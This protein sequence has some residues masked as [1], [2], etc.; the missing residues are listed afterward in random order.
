MAKAT[1]ITIR[2]VDA[3]PDPGMSKAG[4]QFVSGSERLLSVYGSA[5]TGPASPG[6]LDV[7]RK[8]LAAFVSRDEL[9]EPGFEEK[10]AYAQWT[11]ESAR[12]DDVEIETIK[13]VIAH[14]PHNKCDLELKFEY[15]H[16]Y[17]QATGDDMLAYNGAYEAL[18]ESLL[19][20]TKS[21]VLFPRSMDESG[22]WIGALVYLN[23]A[24]D[25]TD[26]PVQGGGDHVI[27]GIDG[28]G[29]KVDGSP[30]WYPITRV[31]AVLPDFTIGIDDQRHEPDDATLL[32]LH[33]RMRA[34]EKRA[35]ELRPEKD[36]LGALRDEKM[37]PE[38]SS[39]AWQRMS[40]DEKKQH[41][42]KQVQIGK[43]VGYEAAY[44]AW[45]AENAQSYLLQRAIRSMPVHTL[46]GLKAKAEANTHWHYD[47]SLPSPEE[48][49]DSHDCSLI[50]MLG[51]IA[52]VQEKQPSRFK[53]PALPDL[54]KLSV[55][56]LWMTYKTLST[57]RD[58][59]EPLEESEDKQV[60]TYAEAWADALFGAYANIGEYAMKSGRH[61]L[62]LLRAQFAVDFAEGQDVRVVGKDVPAYALVDEP[63]AA[64]KA[65]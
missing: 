47:G 20:A 50:A 39:A 23:E 31:S 30:R 44:G 45:Q 54:S 65:A 27:E 10:E 40:E 53:G 56:S 12:L 22:L 13:A 64:A 18:F 4:Q 14:P 49:H 55:V 29:I 24:D 59:L 33:H 38:P 7:V 46:A 28:A 48:G 6:M 15:L 26:D 41:R 21:G 36:R 52:G 42:E 61:E 37:P 17:R 16:C 2:P 51:A 35:D 58:L 8:H 1:N 34:H 43:E 3:K 63:A 5:L 57:M 62:G 60:R 25:D 19:T 32:A 9:G 11:E